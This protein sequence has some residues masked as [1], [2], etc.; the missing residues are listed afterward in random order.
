MREP[1]HIEVSK[2]RVFGKIVFGAVGDLSLRL[3]VA[4]NIMKKGTDWPFELMCPELSRVDILF[5]NMETVLVP[6]DFNMDSVEASELIAP[7]PGEECAAAFERAGFHFLNLAANHVLDAGIVGLEYTQQVLNEAGIAT[8]GVGPTQDE[9]RHP[10]VLFANGLRIGLLCYCEDNNYTLGTTG[11]CHAYFVPEAVEA[12]IESLRPNVDVLI[13]SVHADLEFM[14]TPSVPRR[15]AFRSFV[16]AG[17]DLVLGHHPHVPQGCERIGKS[18]IVYS[19]GNFI[20]PAHSSHYMRKNG[21]DTAWSFL[22]RAEISADGVGHFERVPFQIGKGSNERPIPCHN[23]ARRQKLERLHQLD[24]LVA[25]DAEVARIWG[26][27][28]VNKLATELKL[29]M[30]FNRKPSPLW[31]RG[32]IRLLG[33]EPSTKLEVDVERVLEELVGRWCLTAENRAW[34]E[35]ILRQGKERWDARNALPPDPYHRPH[36]RFQKR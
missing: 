19:L 3:G 30:S 36:R 27:T 29:A 5:G 12:D 21:A 13:V 18:L 28:A 22:L 20:F 10:V 34:M 17:A 6:P 14:P 35:E 26:E 33:L 7:F 25:D 31:K 1:I 11:P 32:L 4:E 8:G 24:Q 2:D 9:A 23:A 16:K 15:D